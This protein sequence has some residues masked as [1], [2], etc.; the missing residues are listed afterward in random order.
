M[1]EPNSVNDSLLDES[2]AELEKA[3]A[4]SPR[5]ISKLES[6]IRS[7]DDAGLFRINPYTFAK[8]RGLNDAEVVDLFLHASARG[9]FGMDWLLLCPGCSTVVDSF[10]SLKSVH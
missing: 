4:W 8:Q 7:G 9:L 2:L 5:L 6:H 3:R 10:R 1:T